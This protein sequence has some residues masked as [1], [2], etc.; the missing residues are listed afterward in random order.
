MRQGDLVQPRV[1]SRESLAC[2]SRHSSL[3]HHRSAKSSLDNNCSLEEEGRAGWSGL[4]CNIL[5]ML[6]SVYI[7]SS[8]L[9][10][11]TPVQKTLLQH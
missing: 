8:V 2:S 7:A 4:R 10:R 11:A 9:T 3:A 1:A 5:I 6:K